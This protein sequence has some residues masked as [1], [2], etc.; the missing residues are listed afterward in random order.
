MTENKEKGKIMKKKKVKARGKRK[1][2]KI[3]RA[4]EFWR[5]EEWN[6]EMKKLRGCRP[7]ETSDAGCTNVRMYE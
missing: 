7:P 6:A 3:G 1:T 2:E 4:N 5:S